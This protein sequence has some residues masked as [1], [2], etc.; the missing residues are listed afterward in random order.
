MGIGMVI[1]V[2]CPVASKVRI[3]SQHDG[4]SSL[5][6][7]LVCLVHSYALRYRVGGSSRPF[8]VQCD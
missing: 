1:A 2:A 7:P 8:L 6:S 3:D 5:Y 4:I